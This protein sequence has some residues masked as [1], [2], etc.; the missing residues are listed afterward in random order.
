LTAKILGN[1]GIAYSADRNLPKSLEYLQRSLKINMD[2][3]DQFS[4]GSTL[5]SMGYAYYEER[6]YASAV[7]SAER[8]AAIAERIGSL[9]IL[10]GALTTSGSAYRKLNQPDKARRALESAIAAIEKMRNLVAGGEQERQQF[11]EG[12]TTPYQEMADLLL[13]QNNQSEALAFAERAK[14][15]TL[16]DVLGSGRVDITKMMTPEET[17]LE[18]KTRSQLVSL[19]SQITAERLRSDPDEHRVAGLTEQLEK[20]RLDYEQVQMNLYAAHPELR[21]QRGKFESI[22]PKE[23]AALFPD[24]NTALLEFLALPGRVT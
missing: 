3:G 22:S 8:A 21:V 24:R 18:Q 16:V 4:I 11:L 2:I 15:R 17:N 1:M 13:D 14:A 7:D 23:C 6:E 9:E 12:R 10:G 19:N 20:A 5:Q